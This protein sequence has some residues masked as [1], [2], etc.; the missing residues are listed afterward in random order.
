MFGNVVG[1]AGVQ[2][3]YYIVQ[4]M[5]KGAFCGKTLH[6]LRWLLRL[7]ARACHAGVISW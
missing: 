1:F 3:V 2:S 5:V 4:S 6:G 7:Q